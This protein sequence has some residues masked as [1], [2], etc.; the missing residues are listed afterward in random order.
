[1]AGFLAGSELS[2]RP[3]QMQ[4]RG[5]F[6]SKWNFSGISFG[7]LLARI[8]EYLLNGSPREVKF[9]MMVAIC[10]KALSS[11]VTQG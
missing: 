10:F 6:L 9:H 3:E 7:G 11:R 5:I 2:P 4:F 8:A 1:M